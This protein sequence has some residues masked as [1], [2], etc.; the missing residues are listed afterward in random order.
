MSFAKLLG[1]VKA[2]AAG[3]EVDEA[4]AAKPDEALHDAA[5]RM[6]KAM[7]AGDA[8]GFSGA[9]ADWHELRGA[10]GPNASAKSEDAKPEGAFGDD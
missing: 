3:S 6:I 7:H 2:P 5:H 4:P 8:P 1:G 10:S 9:L